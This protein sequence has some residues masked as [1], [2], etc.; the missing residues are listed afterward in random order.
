L[1]PTDERGGEVGRKL[2]SECG[3]DEAE[4][5]QIQALQER[6]RQLRRRID[7]GRRLEADDRALLL[8]IVDEEMMGRM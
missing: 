4:L 2:G 5:A 1:V 6:L 7:E 3:G 8:A